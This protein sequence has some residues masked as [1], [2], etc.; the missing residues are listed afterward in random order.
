MAK[1]AI[2]LPEFICMLNYLGSIVRGFKQI[3]KDSDLNCMVDVTYM[4]SLDI[5][6]NSWKSDMSWY[7]KCC[8]L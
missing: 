8:Q 3:F 4:D 7:V 1:R 6:W 2:K 5:M